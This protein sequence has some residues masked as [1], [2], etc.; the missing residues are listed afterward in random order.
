MQTIK[1]DRYVILFS[2]ILYFHKNKIHICNTAQSNLKI[3]KSLYSLTLLPFLECPEFG[4]CD[5]I[6]RD[7]WKSGTV[8]GLDNIRHEF[9]NIIEQVCCRATVN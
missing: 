2:V 3:L 7:F 1:K 9:K 8:G 5:E 4:K 6:S